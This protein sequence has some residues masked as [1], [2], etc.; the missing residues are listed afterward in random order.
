MNASSSQS[1]PAQNPVSVFGS[2]Q[3]EMTSTISGRNYRIFVFQPAGPPPQSGY[4][5]LVTTDGNLSFPLA[6]TVGAT[7][8]LAGAPALVVGIGYPTDDPREL[9]GLRTLDLSPPGSLDFYRFLIEELRPRIAAT[10][11]VNAGEYTLYGYSWGGMFTLSVLFNHPGSFRRFVAS[12]PSI[13]WNHRAVLNDE[14]SFIRKI[15]EGEAQPRV[16]ILVGSKEQEVPQRLPPGTTREH[17]EKMMS[18]ARMVDNARELAARLQPIE[19]GPG[20]SVR[21]HVLEGEDHLTAVSASIGQ[22]LAF[23]LNP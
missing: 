7:F 13:W 1:L 2:I 14:A 9:I 18:E 12:S 21:F 17:M 3:F 5:V 20:Y 23:A 8:A 4:P 11:P 22:A 16:L 15:H 19:G 6:A 10:Y